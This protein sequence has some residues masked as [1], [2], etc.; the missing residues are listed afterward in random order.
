MIQA[1]AEMLRICTERNIGP[2]IIV[3]PQEHREHRQAT[4]RGN[5]V[6]LMRQ[7]GV[8]VKNI[9]SVCPISERAI[10]KIA[11]VPYATPH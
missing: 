8:S 10:R 2:E 1:W 4:A 11:D 6:R 5:V 3:R 9:A 7:S